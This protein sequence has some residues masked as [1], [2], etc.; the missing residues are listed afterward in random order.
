VESIRFPGAS[1]SVSVLSDQGKRGLSTVATAAAEGGTDPLENVMLLAQ[2]SLPAMPGGAIKVGDQWHRAS[3]INAP[4]MLLEAALSNSTLV[5]FARENELTVAHIATTAATPVDVQTYDGQ[6]AP[7]H[8]TGSQSLDLDSYFAPDI[9]VLLRSTGAGHVAVTQTVSAGPATR[10]TGKLTV[11]I[12][13]V[14]TTT[15]IAFTATLRQ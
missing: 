10:K 8:V 2:G 9:H 11:T 5:G 1:R 12:P 15:D 13:P 4:Y 7:L 6:G 3:V 14:H